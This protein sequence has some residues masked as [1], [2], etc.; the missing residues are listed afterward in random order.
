M[1]A[2]RL[3]GQCLMGIYMWG[4]IAFGVPNLREWFYRL[5]TRAASTMLK[6]CLGWLR[7]QL[8]DGFGILFL[9]GFINHSFYV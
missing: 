7:G 4:E 5:C 9:R 2:L 6:I 8:F 1:G 3:N